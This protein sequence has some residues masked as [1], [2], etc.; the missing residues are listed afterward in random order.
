MSIRETQFNFC[1]CVMVKVSLSASFEIEIEKDLYIYHF[2]DMLKNPVEH[3]SND[4]KL[5]D[6]LES[7]LNSSYYF[8][9]IFFLQ[10]HIYTL[11]C[12][13]YFQCLEIMLLGYHLV[14]RI[15]EVL[16]HLLLSSR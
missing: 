10:K 5:I 4:F 6:A 16:L 11:T 3:L 14:L 12:F 13:S 15:L 9:F 2:S 7:H 8:W 1:L